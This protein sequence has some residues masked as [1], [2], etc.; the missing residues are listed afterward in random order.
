VASFISWLQ[1]RTREGISS[2]TLPLESSGGTT[3]IPFT[4]DGVYLEV[5]VR[6]I[7]LTEERRLWREFQP[8]LAVVT[9]FIHQGE[10]RS[11][12]ALLGAGELSGKLALIEKEDAIEIR[13]IRVAGP[14]PYE[15]DNVSILVA[16]FRTET[17]N[18]LNKT[19][20]A[21]EQIAGALAPGSL[22][23][24]KPVADSVI[25]A[26]TRFLD[27][28]AL[29]LRCGQYQGWSR[30]E[31]PDNPGPND[32]RPMHLV[33]MRKPMSDGEPG[34][35]FTVRDGRLHS[36]EAGKAKPYTAH[37]FVLLGIEPRLKRDDYKKLDF[38][39][40]W[41]ATRDCLRAGETDVAEREWRKTAGSLYTDELTETQQQ[42]LYADYKRR[43]DE[44]LGRLVAASV[45]GIDATSVAL[46]EDPDP[47]EIL[48]AAGE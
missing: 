5:T 38:Y 9:D 48:V 34:A 47:A 12:P 42:T 1:G 14:I 27:E 41:Q 37:D 11:L 32:L 7:W 43:Y 19:L 17:K 30:A 21:V 8:F 29:E 26:L 22:I 10:P 33:V 25:S 44:M 46:P 2:F 40:Y 23:A 24:W 36:I 6:Q 20:G 31:D 13:N 35:G 16:L 15:G 45:R 3:P 39:K 18:W 28:E 4:P